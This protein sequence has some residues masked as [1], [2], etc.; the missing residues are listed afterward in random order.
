MCIATQRE[1]Q[2]CRLQAGASRILTQELKPKPTDSGR[3]TGH[4]RLNFLI[5]GFSRLDPTR[6]SIFLACQPCTWLIAPQRNQHMH[7]HEQTMRLPS[8]I[9]FFLLFPSIR[10]RSK[11]DAPFTRALPGRKLPFVLTPNTVVC[12]RDFLPGQQ[13][14]Y[15]NHR[16]RSAFR[17]RRRRHSALVSNSPAT[18]KESIFRVASV[19]AISPDGNNF[20]SLRDR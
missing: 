9:L 14:F 6:R 10:C 7:N 17:T 15:A 2:P 8:V 20:L 16:I 19:I 18:K 1:T 5:C 11:G 12:S 3:N 13:R 4:E